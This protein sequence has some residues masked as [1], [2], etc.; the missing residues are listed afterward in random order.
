M[1][2]LHAKDISFPSSHK[3]FISERN[4]GRKLAPSCRLEK[5]SSQKRL[6]KWD[7]GLKGTESLCRDLRKAPLKRVGQSV[8]EEGGK[9]V[10]GKEGEKYKEMKVLYRSE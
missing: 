3:N 8:I 5:S 6:R 2:H 9:G 10:N 1:L 7:K 4:S